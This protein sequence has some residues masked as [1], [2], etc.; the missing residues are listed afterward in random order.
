MRIILLILTLCLS[1]NAIAFSLWDSA[2]LNSKQS[3]DLQP[4]FIAN[5]STSEQLSKGVG[6]ATF[7]RPTSISVLDYTGATV[8]IPISTTS[9]P[10]PAFP[11]LRLSYDVT[12]GSIRGTELASGG[13]TTGYAYEIIARSS[14]NFTVVGAANNNVGT[15]FIATGSVTLNATNKVKQAAPVWC[16]TVSVSDST[17]V[18]PNQWY[19]GLFIGTGAYV[20][21]DKTNSKRGDIT[22]Y[23]EFTPVVT[24]AAGV[25]PIIMHDDGTSY[26]NNQWNI[27]YQTTI[28]VFSIGN[29]STNL[30]AINTITL[31]AGTKYKI[32]GRLLGN[33]LD[34]WVNGVK[35]ASG[36][37]TGTQATYNG[38]ITAGGGGA[39]T[40]SNGSLG[41]SRIYPFALSDAGC[42][43]LTQ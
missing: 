8:S 3:S 26:A 6:P 20:S 41:Q 33:T 12:E 25:T 4:S 29:G 37:L 13:L 18:I 19:K 43:R 38:A 24:G 30:N 36:T 11:G 14:V 17:L 7:V 9:F 21:Y 2:S 5:N 39:F 16:N 40:S 34:V 27:N 28:V 22:V 10:S 23:A 32:V 31:V 42:L 15:V 1:S 35:G